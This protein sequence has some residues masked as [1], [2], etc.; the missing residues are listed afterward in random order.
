MRR[1]LSIQIE[2]LGSDRLEVKKQ[3]MRNLLK[4]ALPDE[5]LYRELMLSLGYKNNKTQFLEL[6]LITPY[7]E[8]RRLKDKDSIQL[9]LLHRAGFVDAEARLT[10]FDFSLK[11]DK[12]VW[13]L[14][15][16]RPQNHPQ[17]RIEHISDVLDETV[18]KG[19]IFRFFRL[20]IEENY[21]ESWTN[22]L[23]SNQ[24]IANAI[25]NKIMSFAGIG[26]ERKVDMFFNIIL[27]FFL[28]TYE[29]ETNHKMH[30]F[31]E[32]L[33][34]YHKA[35][36]HNSITRAVMKKL[37]LVPGDINSIRGFMGLIQYYYNTRGGKEDGA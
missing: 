9:A 33:Y 18:S 2:S 28:V 8:I 4:I 32:K 26:K 16:T 29:D 37:G 30:D 20:K 13:N 12:G 23:K 36:V 14:E 27:P 25:V 7:S 5:A 15:R 35:L 19:G 6:A 17:K 34:E 11:M 3:R 21:F 10:N 31:L 22:D 1:K 24:K